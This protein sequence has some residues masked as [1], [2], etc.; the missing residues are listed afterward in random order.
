[1]DKLKFAGTN[2][3]QVLRLA[4]SLV[5]VLLTGAATIAIIVGIKLDRRRAQLLETKSAL[6]TVVAMDW[7]AFND[8]YF[9]WTDLRQNIE[10]GEIAIAENKMLDIVYLYPFVKSATLEK[11]SPPKDSQAIESRDGDLLLLFS[12]KDDYGNLPLADWTAVVALNSQDF[13]NAIL[14]QA[15]MRISNTDG[16]DLAYGLRADFVEPLLVWSDYLI[17]LL[18]VL[19]VSFPIH[20]IHSRTSHFFYE[21]KGLESIIYFFE[22]TE[23][24][25]V[26]HSRRVAALAI[27]VGQKMGFKG[28]RLRNL[29]IAALLHDI[30]KIS[31]PSEILQKTG[32]LSQD[33]IAIIQ[34]HPAASANILLN[35]QELAP[36]SSIVRSHH[37]RMDGSGYPDGLKGDAIPEE[38]RIIAVVDVFEALIGT[39]PYRDPVHSKEAFEIMQ[40]TPLDQEIVAVFKANYDAFA[41][42]K[43]PKW[44]VPYMPM[45]A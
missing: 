20:L 40:K 12:I 18:A 43:A 37:E 3:D 5:I 2:R 17:V 15:G 21:T 23:K 35:F 4:R 27:F 1:M 33:E 42:F 24:E 14:P 28:R 39:R 31:V 25:A 22:Q 26:S 16:R 13:L 19:A 7:T 11:R 10:E 44:A 6:V 36:L 30:G 32:P 45:P 9:S 38:S 29:Y 34:K 8:G 41:T